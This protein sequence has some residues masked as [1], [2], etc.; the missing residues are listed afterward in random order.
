M[1]VKAY[2]LMALL[3]S[4]W[5]LAN[6]PVSAAGASGSF[7]ITRITVEGDRVYIFGTGI[8]NPDQCS[9]ANYA[10]I[11]PSAAN[12]DRF[13]SV[14]MTAMTSQRRISLWFVGCVASNWDASAP[15]AVSIFLE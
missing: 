10:V 5:M 1:L 15:Y 9:T 4:L 14:A 8:Q 6:S 7:N 3:V 13:L 12:V 11:L 2:K